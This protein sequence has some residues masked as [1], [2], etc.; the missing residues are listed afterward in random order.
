MPTITSTPIP[1]TPGNG[2]AR[3]YHLTNSGGN[4]VKITNYGG[5]I[6]SIVFG[7]RE[8]VIGFDDPSRYWGTHPYYGALIGRYGNRIAG[9]S[10]SLGGTSYQ[11]TP[12]ENGNQIHGGPQGFD[13]E[14]WHAETATTGDAAALTLSHVSPDG[15]MGY[16]G[17]VTVSCRY[18][19]T[20]ANELRLDYKATSTE[21]TILNLTNHA[22]FNIG[23]RET[24]EDLVLQL[25]ANAYTPVDQQSIPT[26]K[27]EDVAGTPFD[28]TSAKRIGK[29]L[30]ADH[31]QIKIGN[32]YDHNWVVNDY[33][34]SL[35]RVATL[36]DPASG[37]RLT[38]S[39]TEPGVQVFT[40]NFKVGEFPGRG[41]APIVPHGAVC[42]ETQHF[43]DSPNQTNFRTPRLDAGGVYRTTTVYRFEG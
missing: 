11:L 18:T 15:H 21:D 19:W 17:E 33:D 41:G 31:T 39:T 13:K 1:N 7:G 3:L 32:G 26:G 40:A 24:V 10:F 36:S 16:P 12:N 30:R 27:I 8:M 5:I 14:I 29:D 25:D 28:F 43:P 34:G 2:P 9:A 6:T 4:T 22:Y 38:C 42:L 35:R 20:D 37:R 23:N